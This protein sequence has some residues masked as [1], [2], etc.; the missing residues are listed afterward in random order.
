MTKRTQNPLKD[1][2]QAPLQHR[3]L[4]ELLHAITSLVA[5][6]CYL[7]YLHGL[8]HRL[9]YTARLRKLGELLLINLEDIRRAA[10]GA[11][12]HLEAT[13]RRDDKGG[14]LVI[15]GF[16]ARQLRIGGAIACRVYAPKL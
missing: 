12:G 1:T 15:E 2:A 14:R 7:F 6:W 3:N 4:A 8:E 10:F 11:K 13:A 5:S 9:R 16:A